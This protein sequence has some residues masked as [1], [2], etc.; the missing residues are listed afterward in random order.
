MSD[1]RHKAP[2]ELTESLL[3]YARLNHALDAR[4]F[5]L[6]PFS[7]EEAWLG[8][9][10]SMSK[11]VFKVAALRRESGWE[12]HKLLSGRSLDNVT[13]KTIAEIRNVISS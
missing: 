1:L 11:G 9:F 7:D 12:F 3:K 8:S 5:A 4:M 2:E 6:E 13:L 10:S